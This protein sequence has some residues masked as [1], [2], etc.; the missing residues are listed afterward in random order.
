MIV[1]VTILI[2]LNVTV[3]TAHAWTVGDIFSSSGAGENLNNKLYKIDEQILE[4]SSNSKLMEFIN[5]NMDEQNVKVIV[6]DITKKDQVLESYYIY[7]QD[8]GSAIIKSD[9]NGNGN[10]WTFNPTVRQTQAGLKL[11]DS[12]SLSAKL[13]LKCIILW[14]SVEKENNVP[15]TDKIIQ[16]SSW[17]SGSLSK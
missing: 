10:T 3:T 12:E 16:R 6:I 14:I 9:G 5:S 13:V 7:R 2:I 8:E 1:T 11:L 4:L 17:I 15:S